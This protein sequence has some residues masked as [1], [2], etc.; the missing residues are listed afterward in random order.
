M[1]TELKNDIL[2]LLDATEACEKEESLMAFKEK[3]KTEYVLKHHPF[4]I[5]ERGNGEYRT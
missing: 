1:N 4:P 2:F 3:L 5:R